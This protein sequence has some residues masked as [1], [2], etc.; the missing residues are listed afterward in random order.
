[1]TRVDFY[2]NVGDKVRYLADLASKALIRNRRLFI[3]VSDASMAERI[4]HGLWTTLPT[5]FLPHCRSDH[6]L[7][8]ETPI[9]VD[10][11]SDQLVHDDVLINFRTECPLIFSRFNGLV[12]L[13]GHDETDRADARLR[14]RFYRDRGY[15]IRSHDIAGTTHG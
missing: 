9:V 13:V 6:R 1:M 15:E 11:R 10:W 8:A 12:E 5:G 2:F 7:A 3:L 14:Y 4:E